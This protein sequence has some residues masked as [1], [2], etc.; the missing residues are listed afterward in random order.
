MGLQ[1]RWYMQD[2]ARLREAWGRHRPPE[3][4]VPFE[5]VVRTRGRRRW[6]L[7][8]LGAGMV[9]AGL[10]LLW[11]GETVPVDLTRIVSPV[12]GALRDWWMWACN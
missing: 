9:M 1:D 8:G 2:R 5:V 7:A 12:R 4:V 3:R 10:L 6:L 11:S